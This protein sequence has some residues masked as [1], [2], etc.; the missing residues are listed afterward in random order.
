MTTTIGTS[1]APGLPGKLVAVHGPA[2][3]ASKAPE[4]STAAVP[5]A[6]DPPAGQET[7]LTMLVYPATTGQQLLAGAALVLVAVVMIVLIVRS[8]RGLK[9]TVMK[10]GSARSRQRKG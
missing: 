3:A 2:G 9:E 10:P 4:T 7:I 8:L 6:V 5:P 1:A